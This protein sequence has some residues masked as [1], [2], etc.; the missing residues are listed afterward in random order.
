V[1]NVNLQDVPAG[2]IN[3][4]LEGARSAAGWALLGLVLALVSAAA[5]GAA[6]A[7]MWPGRD[8]AGTTT[9]DAESAEL[10]R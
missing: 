4:A 8:T 9:Q 1:Q 7:K 6:G 2:Q 10:R 3:Q 5:G